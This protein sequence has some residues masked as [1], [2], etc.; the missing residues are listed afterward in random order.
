MQRK[1][2]KNLSESPVPVEWLV[3]GC[4]AIPLP[5]DSIDTVMLTYVLCTIPDWG[6]GTQGDSPCIEASR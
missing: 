2:E 5:D 4:E 3:A 1:A 6:D